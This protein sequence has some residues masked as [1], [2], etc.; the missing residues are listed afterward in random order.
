MVIYGN[1]QILLYGQQIYRHDKKGVVMYHISLGCISSYLLLVTIVSLLIS[2]NSTGKPTL[3]QAFA[4]NST[5]AIDAANLLAGDAIQ[6][7]SHKDL[8]GALEHLKLI[9]QHFPQ[10]S[11]K[12]S[13]MA[14]DAA[15]LLAGDAIQALNH[16]D[17]NGALEHLKLIVQELGISANSPS[18]SKF[19]SHTGT[20]TPAIT[21]KQSALVSTH[22][23]RTFGE[24][25]SNPN[26]L[27]SC[28]GSNPTIQTFRT[29]PNPSDTRSGLV[30][31]HVFQMLGKAVPNPNNHICIDSTF[32][33]QMLGKAVPN[34]TNLVST[35]TTQT[36]IEAVPNPTNLVSTH[37]TQTPIETVPN[38][39]NLVST[40]TTQT[41]NHQNTRVVSAPVIHTLS[42]GI[43]NPSNPNTG[44]PNPSNQN[45]AIVSAPVTQTITTMH[46]SN[47]NR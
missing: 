14:I 32:A 37:T 42:S 8:N 31:T 19:V 36:P 7:L 34:P 38:P 41:H 29:V 25:V 10:T 40:H 43:A 39:T 44:V 12:N 2:P 15:N 33:I 35:H 4:Q 5:M 46:H 21:S 28:I 23:F 9:D 27:V 30:S 3:H 6:A 13:T 1:L 11:A 16:K 45:T 24:T 22:I 26:N 20:H 17:L 47:S 18:N